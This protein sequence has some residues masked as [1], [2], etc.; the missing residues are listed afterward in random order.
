M[1]CVYRY[2]DVEDNI[3]KYIGITCRE[4]ENG[5]M[6]RF[7]EHRKCDLWCSG[8]HWKIEYI[9]VP[10]KG[11]A[12]ALEGHFIAL[13]ET[14]KWYNRSKADYGLISFLNIDFEWTLLKNDVWADPSLFSPDDFRKIY[15]NQNNFHWE[16]AKQLAEVNHCLKVINNFLLNEDYSVYPKEILLADKKELE[17]R[18]EVFTNFQLGAKLRLC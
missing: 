12:H 2:T 18:Q 14:N 8:K 7:E 9:T 1:N 10:T 3:I 4:D 5:V 16:V 17:H 6:K 11:D 15:L 13:Y